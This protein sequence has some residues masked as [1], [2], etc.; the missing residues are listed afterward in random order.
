EDPDRFDPAPPKVLEHLLPASILWRSLYSNIVEPG[1]SDE[2]QHPS[3]IG[4]TVP[5]SDFDGASG[6]SPP[7]L[8]YGEE[9]RVVPTEAQAVEPG[10]VGAWGALKENGPHN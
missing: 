4:R 8:A 1:T 10:F 2:Q 7:L 6:K 5:A 3:D 9:K